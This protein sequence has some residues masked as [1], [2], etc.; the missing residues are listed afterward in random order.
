MQTSPEVS[1]HGGAAAQHD[2]VVQRASHVNRTVLDHVV[3]DLRDRRGEV[4]IGEF[5]M[6]ENLRAQE[7]LVADVD[8]ERLARDAVHA[9]VRANPLVR[10]RVVLGELL[11]DVRADVRESLFN[12][13]GS[14]QALL[15]RD[16]DLA[17]PQQALNE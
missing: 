14:F 6:E 1:E 3:D 13:F 9:L 12:C 7:A 16:A 17:L 5:R 15:G 8:V 11:R 4:G 2:V 10:L